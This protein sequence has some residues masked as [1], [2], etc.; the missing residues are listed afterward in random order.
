MADTLESNSIDRILVPNHRPD[1]DV[2]DEVYRKYQHSHPF[3]PMTHFIDHSTMGSEALVGLGLG[4]K[5]K[6]WTSRHPVRPYEARS[7]GIS[8][9]SA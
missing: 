9:A 6:E 1:E 3:L 5:A 8:I 4:N 2:L 7:T